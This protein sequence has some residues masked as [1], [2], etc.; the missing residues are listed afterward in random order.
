[1]KVV[2][3]RLN[4]AEVSSANQRYNSGTDTV[5]F[6]PDG[7][8]TWVDMPSLDPRHSS[9]FLYPPLTSGDVR[10][11]AAANMVKWIKDFLDTVTD[12]LGTSATVFGVAN[13]VIPIYELISGG[14]LTLLAVLTELA[15]TL[16]DLGFAAL[17]SAFTSGTYDDL[18]CCFYC[19]LPADGQVSP[20][21][22]SAIED[23]ITSDLD[24]VAATVV[25]AILFL[26]GEVGLS[27]AG[28]IGA[29]MGD[30]DACA[31]GWD[32]IWDFTIN[33]QGFAAFG[34]YGTYA[35]GVGWQ[36]V[37]VGGDAYS[38]VVVNSQ[39][40]TFDA[41]FVGLT[42]GYSQDP[43][44]DPDKIVAVGTTND[45]TYPAFQTWSPIASPSPNTYTHEDDYSLANKL[46]LNPN[47]GIVTMTCTVSALRMKGNGDAPSF[48]SGHAFP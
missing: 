41:T 48:T 23:K 28:A 42:V 4:P 35:A 21:V 38:M 29:E 34:I 24:T 2:R 8:A 40:I 10:C 19:Y 15:A 5:Q 9:A 37:P 25:N 6:S 45:V 14:S 12:L 11:D 39:S 16:S 31:C 30:C 7:G 43:T 13:A 1:M 47:G 33:E 44:P 20:V 18:L 17:S 27:N 3:K 22:L 26:Q 46:Y 32:W 36:T